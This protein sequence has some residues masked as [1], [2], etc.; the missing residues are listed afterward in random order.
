M[1]RKHLMC[2]IV[3]VIMGATLCGLFKPAAVHAQ[4]TPTELY[5]LLAAGTM[6][7]YSLAINVASRNRDLV[8]VSGLCKAC[9]WD[10][11]N[12][13]VYFGADPQAVAAVRSAARFCDSL[14]SAVLELNDPTVSDAVRAARALD[15][16]VRFADVLDQ[17]ERLQQR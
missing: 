6:E 4:F 14:G 10:L 9:A 3:P 5:V 12:L 8:A 11:Y 15:L 2:A 13:P 16:L 1:S 7:R 17:L